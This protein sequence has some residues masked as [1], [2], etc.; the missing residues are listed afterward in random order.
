MAKLNLNN[1]PN[2]QMLKSVQEKSVKELNTKTVINIPLNEIDENEDNE[3]IFNMSEIKSLAKNIKEEGF[4]GAIEV[5]QKA[6]GRYEIFSGHRRYRAMVLLNEKT[7]P[8]IVSEMPKKETKKRRSLISSNIN[9]R[10]MSPLDIARA[11]QYH[12]DTLMMEDAER[13]NKETKDNYRS[14]E[15]R[16]NILADYFNLNQLTVTRYLKLNKII[17]NIQA[18]IETN[19]LPWTSIFPCGDLAVDIQ[20]KVLADLNEL[21]KKYDKLTGKQVEDVLGKYTKKKTSRVVKQVPIDRT[22]FRI[23]RQLKSFVQD[24]IIVADKNNLLKEINE[25]EEYIKELKKKL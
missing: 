8:A 7:I 16:L 17:P 22:V 20:D 25:I 18:L 15:N 1:A 19:K 12:Y 21:L 14:S 2:A 9:I 4:F 6:D 23:R 3:K 13:S 10:E 5:Y 24:E 11:L